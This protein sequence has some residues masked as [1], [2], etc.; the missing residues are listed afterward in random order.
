[1]ITDGNLV[2]VRGLLFLD[3]SIFRLVA[4]RIVA[5]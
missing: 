1:L 2:R 4:S 5:S 3:G